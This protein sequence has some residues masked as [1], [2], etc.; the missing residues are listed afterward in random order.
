MLVRIEPLSS[1]IAAPGYSMGATT[2]LTRREIGKAILV[3]QRMNQIALKL[4]EELELIHTITTD[5]AYGIE[6]YWH[7]RFADKCTNGEWFHLAP[8]DVRAFKRR[9]FM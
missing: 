8:A 7:K 4:P 5:D 2:I 3:E 1:F 9:K 6:G